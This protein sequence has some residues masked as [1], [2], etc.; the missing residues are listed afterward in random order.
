[1]TD[2]VAVFGK[3]FKYQLAA[4]RLRF[5]DLRATD[6]WDDIS[7]HAHN[8]AFMVA[9]AQK[10]DLLAD[11]ALAMDKAVAQGTGL[12]AF[13]KDFRAIVTKHGWHGWTGEGTKGGEAWRIRTIYRTNMRTSY[14]SGRFAQLRDG[15][16]KYWVYRHGGSLEPRLQHL[17]WDGLILE[18]DHPFWSTHYPPNGWGCTCRV[19]GANSLAGAV[20]R[21]GKQALKLPDDWQASDPRT[22]LPTGISKG[23]GYAPGSSVAKTVS[24]AADKIVQLPPVIGSDF[25][26]SLE[27]IIDRYWPTWVADTLVGGGHDAGLAGVMS[28]D[29]ISA[30]SA[31]GVAPSSAEIM[32]KPGLLNGPKAVRHGQAANALRDEDWVNLPVALR[33]PQSVYLD[34]DSGALLYFLKS[35]NGMPQLA[36]RL[37]QA[38]RRTRIEKRLVNLVVSAFRVNMTDVMGRIKGGKLV[39]LLGSLG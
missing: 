25:G 1:M 7:E 18:P 36:V 2:P 33:D 17:G 9:G 23:W 10:A 20:R 16:F 8:R 26:S 21:G 31:H 30:L 39:P 34:V 37:D 24:L 6:R 27:P 32:V 28:R 13:A 35:G 38:D 12:E 15:N 5:R 11:F 19:F 22:G 4:L 29:V 14:M 3:P